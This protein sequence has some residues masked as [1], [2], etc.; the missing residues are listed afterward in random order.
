MVL[1]LPAT[2]REAKDPPCSMTNSNNATNC[3]SRKMP[4]DGASDPITVFAVDSHNRDGSWERVHRRPIKE[5]ASL[6]VPQTINGAALTMGFFFSASLQMDDSR[7]SKASQD[8]S[9]SSTP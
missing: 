2:A 6:E 5:H 4:G 9:V 8:P 3:P 1:G 7:A